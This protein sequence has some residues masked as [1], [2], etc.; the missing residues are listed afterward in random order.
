MTIKGIRIKK[1][2]FYFSLFNFAPKYPNNKP[3]IQPIIIVPG[4]TTN[5]KAQA[6]RIL[7]QFLNI[8]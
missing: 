6:I 8:Y 1:T 4:P 7:F 3:E 2:F 5:P